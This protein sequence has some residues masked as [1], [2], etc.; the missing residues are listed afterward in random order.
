MAKSAKTSKLIVQPETTFSEQPSSANEKLISEGAAANTA[1]PTPAAGL[2]AAGRSSE[3]AASLAGPDAPLPGAAT[4]T[5]ST[6]DPP[7]SDDQG[8]AGNTAGSAGSAEFD[9]DAMFPP[10]ADRPDAEAEFRAKFPRLTAAF[11]AW[12][13]EHGEPVT[14]LRIKSKVDGFR[15][16]GMAHSKAPTEHPAEAFA[17]PEQLEAIF[18][19]PNLTVELI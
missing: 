8:G 19:E 12:H 3:P 1:K 13:A 9:M 17:G 5:N 4:G 11:E 14:G 16:G 2:D 6:D 10:A 18:A 7:E 15:R